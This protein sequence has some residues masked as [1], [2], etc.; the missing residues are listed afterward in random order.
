[1]KLR[2]AL[3]QCSSHIETIN[4]FLF[5]LLHPTQPNPTLPDSAP[6]R[7]HGRPPPRQNPQRCS[8]RL[9]HILVRHARGKHI[10]TSRTPPWSFVPLSGFPHGKQHHG[11]QS[12]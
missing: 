6:L 8:R 4:S 3:F 12:P 9:R 1:V 11:D 2:I 7:H 5:S 10:L